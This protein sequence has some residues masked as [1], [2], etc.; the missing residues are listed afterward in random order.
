MRRIGLFLLLTTSIAVSEDL[1]GTITGGK[2]RKL[3]QKGVPLLKQ[4]Y[5]MRQ[6]LLAAEVQEGDAFESELRKCI[7]LYDEGTLLLAEALEIRYDRAVNAMLMR[8]A[9]ELAKSQA[10]LMWLQNRRR[11]KQREAEKARQP[12][13]EPK[14]EPKPVPEVREEPKKAPPPKSEHPVTRPRFAPAK[15]PA[16]PTDVAPRR[17]DGLPEFTDKRWLRRERRGIDKLLK[18]YYGALR[19]GKIRHRCKLCAAKGKNRDG[20]MCVECRG[21]GSRINLHYFRKAYWNGFTPLFRD[22]EG[23]FDALKAFLEHARSEPASLG[24]AVKTFKVVAIEPHGAWA[25]VRV[26]LKTDVSET[27]QS[28]TLI[29]IGSGWFFFHPATD[30]DLL[31]AD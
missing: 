20:T 10:G 5:G 18:G 22:A 28:L 24:P 26:A 30:E 2:A 16:E 15:P 6:K 23:A 14:P 13:P 17:A 12:K 27:E 4:A 31:T 11:L 19:P 21:S 1:D 29:R 9:R 25:R 7:R 3:V 8:A